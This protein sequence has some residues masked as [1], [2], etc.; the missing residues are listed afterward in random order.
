MTDLPSYQPKRKRQR[1][2]VGADHS[3]HLGQATK[4]EQPDASGKSVTPEDAAAVPPTRRQP[5]SK[6]EPPTSAPIFAPK[7]HAQRSVATDSSPTHAPQPTTQAQ[8]SSTRP[9]L[10]PTQPPRKRRRAG[11][12]IPILL[13]T[14]LVALLVWPAFLYWFVES[15]LG[16]T[17]ALSGE[18]SGQYTTYLVA[19]SDA[20]GDG[21]I[22]ED[23]TIGERTD[24]LILVTKGTNGTSSVV[25]LPRDTDVEIPGKGRNK[26]NAAYA[27]GGAKLLVRTVEKLTGLTVNH[28]VL[29]KMGGVE[30]LV[31]AVDGIELCSDLSVDDPKSGL[32]WKPGCHHANGETALAFAR[33]RYQDPRGDLGRQDRQ[34]QVISKLVKAAITPRTLLNPATTYDMA[35]SGA[36]S[37]VVDQST[38]PL[39]IAKLALAYRSATNAGLVG[40][41]PISSL[42]L[43]NGHGAAV[44]L[45]PRLI[46]QFWQKIANGTLTTSDLNQL[47]IR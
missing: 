25:S 36:Q 37:L 40:A 4:P 18:S 26:L 7:H 5:M 45:D 44:Q 12:W 42:N 16:R 33:M 46:S 28:F 14:V 47:N 21:A 32:V 1:P 2:T 43:R 34:R 3:D 39:D 38:S 35:K 20:R 31:N 30:N 24:S 6:P 29:V 9:L 13:V 41:P 23:G 17:D 11:R 15:N 8:I 27:F 19:G 22:P 10:A